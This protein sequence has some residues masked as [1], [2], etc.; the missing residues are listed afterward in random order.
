FPK[1]AAFAS[2]LINVDAGSTLGSLDIHETR[3]DL[4]GVDAGS[5]RWL[6][7]I[8]PTNQQ[9]SVQHMTFN[10]PV[11]PPPLPDGGAGLQCG[12]L[13]F[14]DFHVTAGALNPGVPTFPASSTSYPATHPLTP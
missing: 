9:P 3:H 7:A 4:F 1:G 5:T 13:V 2:W 8:N 11:N 10:T 12:R 6:G 14:S